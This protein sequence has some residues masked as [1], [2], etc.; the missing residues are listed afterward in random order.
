MS[1]KERIME[2]SFSL[3]LEKGFDKTSINDILKHLDIARGTLYY[4]FE[5]K[6]AI[7]DAIIEK[8]SNEIF[9]RVHAI[10]LEPEHDAV[11]KLFALFSGMR[12]QSMSGGEQMIDYLNRPQNALLHEKSNSQIIEKIS[13]VLSEI[14]SLGIAQKQFNNAYPQECAKMIL[15]LIMGYLDSKQADEAEDVRQKIE[16][17]IYHLERILGAKKG[18]LQQ[19][20]DIASQ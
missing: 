8:A 9:E 16:I 6:E 18:R 3:F 7:M 2:V 13:P 14:I 5:S 10:V 12:M 1:K 11:E 20:A 17:L 4:H 19:L 15:I